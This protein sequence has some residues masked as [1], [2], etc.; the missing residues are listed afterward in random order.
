MPQIYDTGV[1]TGVVNSLQAPPS[2]LVDT[3]F[4]TIQT[5]ESEEIHFDVEDDVMAIAPFVSP[6]V[7]GQIVN[8]QGYTTKSMKPAYIKPKTPVSPTRALK[9]LPGEPIAGNLSNAARMERIVATDL[10]M[11]RKLIDRRREWMAAQVLRTGAVTISG[12]KYPTTAVNFGRAGALTVVKTVGNKWGDAGI[13]PLD[14]LATWGELVQDNSGSAAITVVMDTAAWKVFR[15]N[16]QV[17]SRLDLLRA[18]GSPTLALD[19][20]LDYGGTYRGS[21]DGFN[22]WVYAGTYKDDAGSIQKMLPTGTVLMVGALEGVQAF[23]AILDEEA[24]LQA[25]PYFSKS[26]LIPDPGRRMLMTQCA[27]LLVPYRPNASLCATVL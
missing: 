21:I 11:H 24:G 19:A 16:S 26:W 6:V 5:E 9:R 25:L 12:D 4:P 14:D 10:M 27:P 7:E 22:I 20:K 13:S 8:E 1:L 17:Q 15:A 18:G 23:G 2:F 3:F